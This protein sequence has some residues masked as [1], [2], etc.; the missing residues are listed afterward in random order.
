MPEQIFSRRR[1][2]HFRRVRVAGRS[3]A[4]FNAAK[5]F[6]DHICAGMARRNYFKNRYLETWEGTTQRD[7][8]RRDATQRN[9]TRRSTHHHHQIFEF[10]A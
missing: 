10:S 1:A 5:R 6:N 9:A 3:F 8:T 4:A 2:T 7:A